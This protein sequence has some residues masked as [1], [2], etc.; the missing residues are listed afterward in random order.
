M[1]IVA[2]IGGTN[3]RFACYKA[4][5]SR[6]SGKAFNS[7]RYICANF[8]SMADA[9]TSYFEDFKS[10]RCACHLLLRVLLMDQA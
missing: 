1:D 9:L 2:D 3:A 5:P 6:Q 8:P 10:S 4:D 7:A